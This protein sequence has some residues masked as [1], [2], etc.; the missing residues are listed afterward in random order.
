MDRMLSD[1]Y[2][3]I[4]MTGQVYTKTQQLERM[5]SK[6]FSLTQIR[7]DERK[8]KLIGSIAI[9]TSRADIEGVS[10][11]MPVKGTFRYTRVYRRTPSGGWKITSFEATRVPRSRG[12]S[13]EQPALKPVPRHDPGPGLNLVPTRSQSV[14]KLSSPTKTSQTDGPNRR[15]YLLRAAFRAIERSIE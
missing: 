4:S 6:K 8:V 7:F 12:S 13:N 9:V 5:R 15:T 10:D 2:I 3:G 11:E 1:D 14:E